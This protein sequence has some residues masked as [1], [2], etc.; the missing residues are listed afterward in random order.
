[1]QIEKVKVVQLLRE[2]GLDA[3]ADWVDK[4]LPEQ[5][6]LAANA[7][8]LT[9]LHLTDEDISA[10]HVTTTDGAEAGA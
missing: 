6:D 8:L 4:T 10:M 9:T 7:S 5:V 2:R 1:M 3:R